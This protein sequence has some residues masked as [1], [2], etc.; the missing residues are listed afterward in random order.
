MLSLGGVLSA[1]QDDHN[2]GAYNAE[3]SELDRE[4]ERFIAN[5]DFFQPTAWYPPGQ[6]LQEDSQR[7]PV[8]Q[9]H[10]V[11]RQ[12]LEN[13]VHP[14]ANQGANK[15]FSGSNNFHQRRRDV[16]T[17]QHNV[18][19]AYA[20]DSSSSTPTYHPIH[21]LQGNTSDLGKIGTYFGDRTP[22]TQTSGSQSGL[23]P[24]MASAS[25]FDSPTRMESQGDFGSTPHSLKRSFSTKESSPAATPRK[26]KRPKLEMEGLVPVKTPAN[27]AQSF[28]STTVVHAII[29][30]APAYV[31]EAT[32]VQAA[33]LR[34]SRL[35]GGI[36][37]HSLNITS[38][39]HQQYSHQILMPK[40]F[41]RLMDAILEKPGTPPDYI[42]NDQKEEFMKKHDDRYQL[43]RSLLVTDEQKLDAIAAFELS[44][45]AARQLSILGIPVG[46]LRAEEYAKLGDKQKILTQSKLV[47]D[48]TSTFLQR[49]DR[50]VEHCASSAWLAYDILKRKNTSDIVAAPD[51]YAKSKFTAFNSNN[52]RDSRKKDTVQAK[53]KVARL[54]LE[55]SVDTY[56]RPSNEMQ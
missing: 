14:S 31:N 5:P 40:V 46:D 47:V 51:A 22:S 44:V 53:A 13:R 21:I 36:Q 41:Q 12:N 9:E 50:L 25:P 43:C 38:D 17:N 1:G 28:A 11:V 4:I 23:R 35:G 33:K 34:L 52:G 55:G 56:G 39:D 49:L 27:A 24:S 42:K 37:Y 48:Q 26:T 54:E 3:Q 16:G 15:P 18:L 20:R 30:S 29:Q 7:Q 19:P 6:P 10:P 8:H 2:R 45:F 32:S